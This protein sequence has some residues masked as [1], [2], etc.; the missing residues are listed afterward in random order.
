MVPFGSITKM[1]A[2]GRSYPA[3]FSKISNAWIATISGS[4]RIR[5]FKLQRLV[6]RVSFV[7]VSGLRVA[8]Q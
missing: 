3:A 2:F 4:D 1:I 6:K 7:G 8:A 5:N